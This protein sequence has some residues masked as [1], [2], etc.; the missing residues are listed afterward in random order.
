MLRAIASFCY[1]R[2]WLVLGLWVVAFVGIQAAAG[3]AGDGYSQEF[4]LDGTESWTAIQLVDER[5]PERS[6]A[7]GEIVFAAEAG[8][9]DPAVQ[10]ELESLFADVEAL[11]EV[12]AVITPYEPEGAFQVAPPSSEAAGTIGYATIQFT[13][14]WS[15]LSEDT[16]AGVEALVD[17]LEVDGIVVELGGD[18]FADQEPPGTSELFGL[19]AAVFI[20]LIAFGLADQFIGL[21][22]RQD[23]AGIDGLDDG[24]L[25]IGGQP[26]PP[27]FG[28]HDQLVE[29]AVIGHRH[30]VLNFIEVNVIDGSQRIFLAIHNTLL[31]GSVNLGPG[32]W[33]RR[34]RSE[35]MSK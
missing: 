21:V 7:D 9:S 24:R 6:G 32:H 33:R 30:V 27:A 8:V 5:F 12:E 23:A 17:D 13:D 15:D 20:L 22:G 26:V 2:R 11:D 19:V 18:V 14:G 10:A 31:E 3:A 35:P 28:K 25:T 29:G 34:R 4:E 16:T 1:R